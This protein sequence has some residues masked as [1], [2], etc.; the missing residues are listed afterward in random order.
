M[1]QII[2]SFIAALMT[3]ISINVSM[4]EKMKSGKM[5][6]VAMLQN[7]FLKMQVK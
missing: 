6:R 2:K 1:L 7:F 3:N 4:R 5:Y